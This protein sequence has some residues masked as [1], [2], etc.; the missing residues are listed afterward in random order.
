MKTIITTIAA[1]SAMTLFSIL[2]TVLTGKQFNEPFIIALLFGKIGIDNLTQLQLVIGY[3]LHYIIGLAFV[4]IFVFLLKKIKLEPSLI[5]GAGYGFVIGIV[6]ILSWMGIII[7]HPDPPS[8][9]YAAFYGQ[10]LFAH[11]VFGITAAWTYRS[12]GR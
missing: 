3:I 8:I 12:V 7:L 11:I 10:L 2:L 5:T 1:T 4:L 6:G 9:S